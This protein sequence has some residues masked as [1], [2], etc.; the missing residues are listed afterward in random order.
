MYVIKIVDLPKFLENLTLKNSVLKYYM[1]M[2]YL[3]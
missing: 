1:S 2:R 3:I